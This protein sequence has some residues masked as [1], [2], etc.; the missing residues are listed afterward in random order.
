MDAKE[1][2]EYVR[3]NIFELA[4]TSP[5][6]PVRLYL[7]SVSH[8]D[9]EEW[10]ILEVGEQ[11]RILKKFE[12]DGEIKNLQ[13]D[14][15]EAIFEILQ[16]ENEKSECDRNHLAQLWVLWNQV[17]LIVSA[18]EANKSLD[19][20][21]L[22]K[23][24]REIIGKTEALIE[25]G[26]LGDIRKSYKRPFTSL[27]T[28]EI[29]A[30][31]KKVGS[32]LDLVS[33][34]LLVIGALEPDATEIEKEMKKNIE[35][36]RRVASATRAIGGEKLDVEKLSYAQALFVLKMDVEYISNILEAASTGYL[37]MT[38]TE[39]NAKYI[40]LT[41]NMED[42][43][44]RA[45]LA[46][47][48]IKKPDLPEH[49]YQG[50]DE[51]GTW[52]ECGGQATILGFIGDI[53]SVWVRKGQQ[54]F[55]ISIALSKQFFETD[56]IISKHKKYKAEKW[57]KLVKN[58][59][60]EQ[61]SETQPKTQKVLHEHIHRVDKNIQENGIIFKHLSE[62][63]NNA[64]YYITKKDDD[65]YYKGQYLKLS[66]KSEYYK[67]FCS[68]YAK[69]PGGGEIK[70]KELAVEIHS[71]LPATKGKTNE[72]MTKFIQDNLTGSK[73][74]FFRYAGIPDT[75]DNGKPL[76]ETMRGVGVRFNNRAG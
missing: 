39:L 28:S 25:Q 54:R 36:V 19:R 7:Y 14:G 62:K 27:F 49:L 46:D 38:D 71:R 72:E 1:K 23:L 16:I 32:P 35:L 66:K 18:Y 65:F 9:N 52:W 12:E 22:D 44:G 59:D 5:S 55:P 48:K 76:I 21:E 10:T 29:E 41:D 74:G 20:D 69:L 6:G 2:I 37:S 8:P 3:Q 67:V 56:E 30:R 4:L 60:G 63:G 24:Y 70:Y 51:M 26:K 40:L 34:F 50:P 57:E 68:L 61:E 42:L 58:I 17:T 13:I 15:R 53:E 75:E 73:N 45:D 31:A 47:L 64:S 43:L 33:I 11:K